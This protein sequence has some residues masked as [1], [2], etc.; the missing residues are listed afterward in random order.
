MKEQTRRPS[1]DKVMPG[2]KVKAYYADQGH[3]TS[4][5][6]LELER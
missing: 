2:D 3:V 1:M 5:Q 6:R 4:L